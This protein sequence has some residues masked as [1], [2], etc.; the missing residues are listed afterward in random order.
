MYWIYTTAYDNILYDVSL[1]YNSGRQTYS[2][3][4]TLQQANT[5]CETAK[6]W[7]INETSAQCSLLRA[8]GDDVRT[9]VRGW[10]RRGRYGMV[11]GGFITTKIYF[12][13][14]IVK[15]STPPRLVDLFIFT[16]MEFNQIILKIYYLVFMSIVFKKH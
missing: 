2:I 10:G 7:K 15:T 5:T 3:Y 14:F 1:R 11:G 6:L 4:T 13:T 8:D 9:R 12:R 16:F